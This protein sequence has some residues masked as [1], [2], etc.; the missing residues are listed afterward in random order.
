M[1]QG[2]STA[3]DRSFRPGLDCVLTHRSEMNPA[4]VISV[5]AIPV[6]FTSSQDGTTL[7]LQDRQ[8]EARRLSSHHCT[9]VSVKKIKKTLFACDFRAFREPLPIYPQYQALK[10]DPAPNSV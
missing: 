10:N 6:S 5:C 4:V 7:S 2:F 8:A 9:D 1:S 3:F